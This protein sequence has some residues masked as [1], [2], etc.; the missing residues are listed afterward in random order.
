MTVFRRRISLGGGSRTYYMSRVVVSRDKSASWRSGRWYSNDII[1]G[2]GFQGHS[3]TGWE[4]QAERNI[5]PFW[6]RIR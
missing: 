5:L 1:L 3:G 6:R 4:R 2:N